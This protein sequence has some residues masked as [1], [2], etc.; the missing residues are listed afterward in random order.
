[1]QAEPSVNKHPREPP[2]VQSLLYQGRGRGTPQGSPALTR[3]QQTLEWRPRRVIAE[4][5]RQFPVLV[6]CVSIFPL[7]FHSSPTADVSRV[8]TI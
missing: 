4:V 2:L 3:L 5:L 8:A 6:K 1:M 7:A